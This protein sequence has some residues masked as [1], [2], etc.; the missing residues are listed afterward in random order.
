M[1]NLPFS[2]SLENQ[3]HMSMV[4]RPYYSVWCT[5]RPTCITPVE[6]VLIDKKIDDGLL[7]TG[8]VQAAWPNA[9]CVS[10]GAYNIPLPT[11]PAALFLIPVLI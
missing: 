5:L 3:R 8:N 1:E 11:M 4:G 9:N 7:I 6:A 2:I 10:G